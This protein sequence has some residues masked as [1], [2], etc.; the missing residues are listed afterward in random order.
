MHLEIESPSWN[1]GG[2]L[3]ITLGW[4][5]FHWY[6]ALYF[7]HFGA[8]MFVRWHFWFLK[9]LDAFRNWISLC[10]GQSSTG[11]LR[12]ITQPP[13][14]LLSS[15]NHTIQCNPIIQSPSPLLLLL[16]LL[17]LLPPSP[18]PSSSQSSSP[19]S[20][21]LEKSPKLYLFLLLKATLRKESFFSENSSILEKRAFP[22]STDVNSEG[23]PPLIWIN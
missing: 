11:T 6:S 9:K 15:Y 4:S 22:K 1:G 19:L 3:W 16:L 21:L 2:N 23:R 17:L 7:F 14:L 5:E 13:S 10:D 12:L 8:F 20:F 18:F